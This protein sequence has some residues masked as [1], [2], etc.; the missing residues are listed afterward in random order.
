MDITKVLGI[1][2]SL[3]CIV[4]FIWSAKNNAVQ[5]EKTISQITNKIDVGNAEKKIILDNIEKGVGKCQSDLDS[6]NDQI[7]KIRRHK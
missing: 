1:I 2:T 3:I 4:T 7:G 5:S 6:I